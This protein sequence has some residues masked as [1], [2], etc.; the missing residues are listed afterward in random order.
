MVE[1]LK[2]IFLGA[3]GAVVIVT[4]VLWIADRKFPFR[5]KE[6]MKILREHRKSD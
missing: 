6:S 1:G 5:I 4:I 2:E 3:A